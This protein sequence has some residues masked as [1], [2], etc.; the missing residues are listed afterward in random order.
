MS[1]VDE[2]Q[3]HDL[4]DLIEREDPFLLDVREVWE[5]E[6]IHIPGTVNI[7]LA[8]VTSRLSDIPRER[9]IV[10]ICRSGARSAKAG[11]LLMRLGYKSVYNLAG[12]T[13]AWAEKGPAD[14]C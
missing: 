2:I 12:G 1:R 5:W 6:E 4:D 8:E 10:S 14:E 9:V 3:P 11:K 13:L 7:P